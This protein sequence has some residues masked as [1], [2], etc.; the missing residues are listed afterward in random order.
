MLLFPWDELVRVTT[1]HLGNEP[2][3]DTSAHWHISRTIGRGC[4]REDLFPAFWVEHK[5]PVK[6]IRTAS[7]FG[8]AGWFTRKGEKLNG[9]CTIERSS[10]VRLRLNLLLASLHLL[11]LTLCS[12][13]QV[14]HQLPGKKWFTFRFWAKFGSTAHLLWL[15][16]KT[17][18]E[19]KQKK[20]EGEGSEWRGGGQ[21]D[22]AGQ[23]RPTGSFY[24]RSLG[25]GLTEVYCPL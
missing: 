21:R 8:E 17:W 25:E 15:T 12:F 9:T 18:T 11:S 6:G 7:N 16:P 13:S 2:A 20:S 22:G 4:K 5:S 14:S 24:V 19:K 23:V 1:I 3:T 10:F